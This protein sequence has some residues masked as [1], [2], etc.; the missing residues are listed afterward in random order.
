MAYEDLTEQAQIEAL[1]DE[2]GGAAIIDFWSPTCGPCMAMA[3]DFEAV[4]D[5]FK[6]GPVR[7]CKVNTADA[8]LLAGA[9]KI[10]SVPTLLFIHQGDVVDA[11]VGRVDRGRL[12]KR[13]QWL[14]KKAEG[15]GLFARLFGG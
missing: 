5:E 2:D 13:A 8:P 1:M 4:A 6:G 10:R 7:F 15:K 9:F 14:A 11:I 3:P 12:Q